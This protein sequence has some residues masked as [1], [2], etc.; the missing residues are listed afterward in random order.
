MTPSRSHKTKEITAP[1]QRTAARLHLLLTVAD[2]GKPRRPEA[3][4]TRNLRAGF[5]LHAPKFDLYNIPELLQESMA[6][7]ATAFL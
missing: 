2:Y 4:Q 5:V 3:P 1:S 6:A 7:A